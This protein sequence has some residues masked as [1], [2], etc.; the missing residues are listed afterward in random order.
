MTRVEYVQ[1]A[2]NAVWRRQEKAKI[3]PT[4]WVD[5]AFLAKTRYVSQGGLTVK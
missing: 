3:T 1:S 4:A 5:E 2:N